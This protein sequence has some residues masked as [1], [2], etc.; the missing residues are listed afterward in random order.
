[1]YNYL[2]PS[3]AS[4]PQGY[5]CTFTVADDAIA[6]RLADGAGKVLRRT[7]VFVE[8]EAIEAETAILSF[9]DGELAAGENEPLH[10]RGAGRDDIAHPGYL[11]ISYEAADGEPCFATNRPIT[12]YAIYTAPGRKAFFSDNSQKFSNPVVIAQIARFGEY[13]DGYPVVNIDRERDYGES[14]VLINPYKKP[15][16]ARIQAHDGRD[17][18]RVRVPAM[19]ARRI[20]LST[21]LAPDETRWAGRIQMTANNRLVVY[22]VKHSLADP[23]V[24]SDHEHMDPFRSDPTHLPASQRL[25]LAIGG[26]LQQVRAV[27]GAKRL[28]R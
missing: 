8:G 28:G 15:V 17:T 19:A 2:I 4:L 21:L 22:N 16:L 10:W 1:M 14:L 9:E 13:V 26:W 20:D 5:D 12:P 11:E 27:A 6:G 23:T 18:G 7:E 3:I 25:R 24:I